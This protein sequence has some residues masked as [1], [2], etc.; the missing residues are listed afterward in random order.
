[1]I[2]W[3]EL[4]KCTTPAAAVVR[5]VDVTLSQQLCDTQTQVLMPGMHVVLSLYP[6]GKSCT[7]VAGCR[8]AQMYCIVVSEWSGGC[9][10]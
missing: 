5:L 3:A 1:V 6:S 4:R 2:P 10:D 8:Q 7:P 9:P